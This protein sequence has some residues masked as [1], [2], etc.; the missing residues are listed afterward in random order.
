MTNPTTR[1]TLTTGGTMYT[2]APNSPRDQTEAQTTARVRDI[3][4]AM[5]DEPQD[6]ATAQRIAASGKRKD[7]D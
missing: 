3:W 2:P 4:Q 6:P 7:R 5:L 1:A